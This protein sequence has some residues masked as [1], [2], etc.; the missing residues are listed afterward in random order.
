MTT[1]GVKIEKNDEKKK[2]THWSRDEMKKKKWK[3]KKILSL[4][5]PGFEPGTF[6]LPGSNGI[7]D[8]YQS[9]HKKT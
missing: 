1:K 4:V 3:K 9:K 6:G 2:N 7:G 8:G 5:H